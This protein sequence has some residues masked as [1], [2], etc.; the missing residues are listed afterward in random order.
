MDV[1]GAWALLSKTDRDPHVHLVGAGL[2]AVLEPLRHRRTGVRASTTG[3]RPA[4]AARR[5]AQTKTYN[6]KLTRT[7]G[8][9]RHD[10]AQAHLARRRRR[11]SRSAGGVALP[12]NKAVTVPVTV[13]A[14]GRAEQRPPAGRRPGHLGG[15]LRGAQHGGHRRWRRRSRRTRCAAEG[16][17]DRNSTTSY[18]VTVPEGATALQVNLSGIATGSQTRWI[19]INPWGVPVESTS[20]PGLLHQLLGRRTRACKPQERAYENPI[21]GVWELEVESRRT[22]PALQ[23]PFELTAQGPGRHGR[24]GGGRAAQRHGRGQPTPVTWTVKNNFGPIAVTGQ[25]RPA[26]QRARQPADDRRTASRRSTRWWCPRA[27]SGSTSRSATPA[28]AAADLDLTV[29]LGGVQVAQQADGDSEEAVSIPNPAAGT[30]TVVV[31]GYSVPS[32]STAYDYLDVYYSPAL[33]TV[34]V[35]ATPVTLAN[36]ATTTVTGT[37]TVASVPPAGRS[38]FGEVVFTTSEGAVVGRGSVQIGRSASSS[39]SRTAE[40]ARFRPGGGPVPITIRAM[41]AEQSRELTKRS[42]MSRLQHR[43]TQNGTDGRPHF[44]VCGGDALVYTLAEE[45]ANAGHRIRITVIV[46]HEAAPR[47]AGPGRPAGRTGDPRRPPRRAHLPRRRAGRRRRAGPGHAG[48]RRQP[49]RRALRPGRRAGPAAGHPDVQHRPRVRRAPALRR[50]RGALRRR[51]GRPGVRRRRAGRGGARPTSGT[52]AA[53]CT[54]RGA[55]DVPAEARGLCPDRDRRRGSGDVL[56]A[57]PRPATPARPIWCWPRRPAGPP[58]RRSPPGGWRD[59]RR[60]RRAAAGAGPG[61][62]GRAEPQARHRGAGHP[63]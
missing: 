7:T 47:R 16:T 30:Y 1:N 5:P 6:V 24:P 45:L 23:N 36:G 15:R 57:E 17:V 32:G 2:H 55:S 10:H 14:E 52:P 46:P 3:A 19:A 49:A 26:G 11:P 51:D 31:D 25:R 56:P 22:S 29:Y 43:L 42:L 39:T 62:P 35:P 53:P 33:G 44:V 60:R 61:D 8:P 54:W 9:S 40:Q 34:E 20:T 27:P 59:P 18:F 38:L 4:R 37:V 21:P 41:S 63:A 48:R 13:T 58:G 12:L 50:L 28:T